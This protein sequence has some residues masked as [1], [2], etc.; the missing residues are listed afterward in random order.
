[1]FFK[2]NGVINIK[3]FVD[4]EEFP[5]YMSCFEEVFDITMDQNGA[6]N[7][8]IKEDFEYKYLMN[9]IKKTF[10]NF[11]KAL[12]ETAMSLTPSLL[13]YNKF[14]SLDFNKIESESTHNDLNKCWSNEFLFYY[15]KTI[16]RLL[17]VALTGSQYDAGEVR[18]VRR[19][20]EV[21]SLQTDC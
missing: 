10:A 18:T 21:L 2:Y 7:A 15:A 6:L 13:Y 12:D 17:L 3:N 11:H 14:M 1:M 9:D 19:I 16:N 5:Q 8:R 4:P 20:G